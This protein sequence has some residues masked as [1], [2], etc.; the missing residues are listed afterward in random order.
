[1]TVNIED[2]IAAL[3]WIAEQPTIGPSA[4]WWDLRARARIA[5]GLPPVALTPAELA[6]Q[7]T[8]EDL[9]RAPSPP[10]C[11]PRIASP[12]IDD[13]GFPLLGRQCTNCED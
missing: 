1:M 5:L 2:A 13:D 4:S 10:V 8:H 12:V 7:R 6:L 9:N 3:R 11:P